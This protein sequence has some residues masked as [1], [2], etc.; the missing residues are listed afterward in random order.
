MSYTN[1]LF[2]AWCIKQF[3]E[4][5]GIY[6]KIPKE[7]IIL[8]VNLTIKKTKI[9]GGYCCLTI[10]RNG[11]IEIKDM[12]YIKND[13]IEITENMNW[14]K[15]YF[16]LETTKNIKA[17]VL[18]HKMISIVT[19][20]NN[21]MVS[22]YDIIID[23]FKEF[24]QEQNVKCAYKIETTQNLSIVLTDCRKLI[25]CTSSKNERIHN[26]K[27]LTLDIKI[28]NFVMDKNI[29]LLTT[30]GQIYYLSVES[31][32]KIDSNP[33][34]NLSL[35]KEVPI[36]NIIKIKSNSTFFYLLNK[37][38]DVYVMPSNSYSKN[39]PPKKLNLNGIM[40]I[41]PSDT[42]VIY[43]TK[44]NKILSQKINNPR[45]SY[46]FMTRNEIIIEYEEII[47]ENVIY[48]QNHG[49]YFLALD[50]NDTIYHWGNSSWCIPSTGIQLFDENKLFDMR[51]IDKPEFLCQI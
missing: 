50:F 20:D 27:L 16:K 13:R 31:I 44:N 10:V 49:D 22:N 18:N 43:L 3:S 21:I 30:L 35:L 29:L 32:D 7:V 1:Q 17:F 8:I 5:D 14:S 39:F 12:T 42:S 2:Y 26:F 38:G 47:L 25:F 24:C 23:G 11:K 15:K 4:L 19:S 6:L 28:K 34:K 36:A 46:M 40:H 9:K 45:D 41:Y 48:V 37:Y 51:Y 33:N